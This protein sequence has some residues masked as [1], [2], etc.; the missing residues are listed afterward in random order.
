MR[1]RRINK[2]FFAL[3]APLRGCFIVFHSADSSVCGLFFAL[4]AFFCGKSL[5]GFG[6]PRWVRLWLYP[7]F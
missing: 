7:L 1:K 6:L 4:F 5:F 3:F 2:G